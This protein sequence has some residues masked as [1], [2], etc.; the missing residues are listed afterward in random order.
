MAFVCFRYSF[1]KTACTLV[2]WNSED[3][4]PVRTRCIMGSMTPRM[5]V[6]LALSL[7]CLSWCSSFQI[8]FERGRDC[9]GEEPLTGSEDA[10]QQRQIEKD[11][12]VQSEQ[13]LQHGIF[14]QVWYTSISLPIFEYGHDLAET[15]AGLR[16]MKVLLEEN[17]KKH[18]TT[19]KCN[20]NPEIIYRMG[21]VI[22]LAIRAWKS[23]LSTSLMGW[24]L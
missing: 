10:G 17:V 9:L 20:S 18:M 16:W 11:V 1:A 14:L 19:S 21:K 24:L 15:P 3:E 4:V 2:Q 13:S 23:F 12:E 6:Y 8:L 5:H 22:V 7:T